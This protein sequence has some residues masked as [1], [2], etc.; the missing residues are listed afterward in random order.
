[1]SSFRFWAMFCCVHSDGMIGSAALVLSE[2]FALMQTFSRLGIIKFHLLLLSAYRK[3][4]FRFKRSIRPEKGTW[5]TLL[6]KDDV[7]CLSSVSP[8]DSKMPY[9]KLRECRTNGFVAVII[10]ERLCPLIVSRHNLALLFFFGSGLFAAIVA[11]FGAYS[12]VKYRRTAVR[13]GRHRGS[14]RFV[15]RSS[16][17]SSLFRDLVFRMCHFCILIKLFYHFPTF[18][19]LGIETP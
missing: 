17:I 6:A 3:R 16:F 9:R 11:A 4:S 15:V 18:S 5:F 2:T 8:G 1:M 14:H 10:N 13:A 19:R 12:V 7:L